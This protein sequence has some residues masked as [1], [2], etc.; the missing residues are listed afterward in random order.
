MLLALPATN[1]T[2]LMGFS[3]GRKGARIKQCE[4]FNTV[5]SLNGLTIWDRVLQG[6]GGGGDMVPM[7][8]VLQNGKIR[9]EMRGPP[10]SLKT[11]RNPEP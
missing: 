4:A 6:G 10:A 1:S 2:I 8:H 11:L 9:A 3:L 7:V 5:R